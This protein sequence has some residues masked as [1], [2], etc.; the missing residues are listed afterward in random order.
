MLNAAE[1]RT[2]KTEKKD[3]RQCT[4]KGKIVVQE[5]SLVEIGGQTQKCYLGRTTS[6]ESSV[7]CALAAHRSGSRHSGKLI[8]NIYRVDY[9]FQFQP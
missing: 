2:N 9:L 3:Q 6:H 7:K 4:W 5:T 1:S 8:F